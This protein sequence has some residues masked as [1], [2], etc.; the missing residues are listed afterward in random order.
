[1][2]SSMV[3]SSMQ[4]FAEHKQVLNNRGVL[5]GLGAWRHNHLADCG[6]LT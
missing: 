2:M 5:I 6:L 4:Y 1:M 3:S